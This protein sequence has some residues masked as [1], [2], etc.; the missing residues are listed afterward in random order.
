MQ[1]P[2]PNPL[3]NKSAKQ[4][5]KHTNLRNMVYLFCPRVSDCYAFLSDHIANSLPLGSVK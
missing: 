3:T 1:I 4:L 2:K 5:A